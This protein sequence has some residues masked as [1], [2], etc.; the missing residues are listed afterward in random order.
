MLLVLFFLLFVVIARFID[1]LNKYFIMFLSFFFKLFYTGF[2]QNNRLKLPQLN[3]TTTTTIK[4]T[5]TRKIN[6][7]WY[8]WHSSGKSIVYI[9]GLFSLCHIATIVRLLLI[10]ILL[11]LLLLLSSTR[12]Y[13]RCNVLNTL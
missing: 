2:V 11:L 1:H 4:A 12:L 3:A 5:I 7:E 13:L 9:L 10:L 6:K 8:M